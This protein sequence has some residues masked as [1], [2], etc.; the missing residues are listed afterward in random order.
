[1]YGATA[2]FAWY[3][4]PEKIGPF[5]GLGGKVKIML[6]TLTTVGSTIIVVLKEGND[7][8]SD[9]AESPSGRL[10]SVESIAKPTG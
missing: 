5:L 9:E 4:S 7:S 8:W 6:L 2:S 3:K 10:S 1:M